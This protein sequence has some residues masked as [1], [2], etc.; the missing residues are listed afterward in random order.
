MRHRIAL[1]HAV[2]VAMAP[3]AAAFAQHWPEAERVNLLDDSLSVDR[4]KTEELTAAVAG[5][6]K[7]LASYAR[8]LGA[9]GVLFTCS[10]FGEA[11]EAAAAEARCPVLKPNEAM[12]ED[13][14]QHGER[15]GMLATFQPSV[16]SME[17][18]FRDLLR[19]RGARAELRTIC[20]PEAMAALRAG[21]EARHNR[22]L[23]EAVPQ[24]ADCDAIL[25]AHFSTSRAQ[26]SVSARTDRPVLTSPAS[27][28][29]KL[30][31]ALVG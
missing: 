19:Q 8:G 1:I 11:I 23:A 25:L 15:I 7:A 2:E 26:A 18:E 31:Q 24:F 30:K 3:I 16:E 10:A 21:D 20:V 22:L 4:A 6:I 29:L 27:A 17:E 14:L 9:H 13:A 5:R 12:F 28:V